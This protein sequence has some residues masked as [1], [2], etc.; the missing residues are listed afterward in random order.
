MARL[1]RPMANVMPGESEAAEAEQ[2][3]QADEA[4]RD[5]SWHEYLLS[6]L[7]RI[8][9]FRRTAVEP[10]DLYGESEPDRRDQGYWP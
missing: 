9:R 7:G 3:L 2:D 5:Q 10:D 8:F 4:L 1:N 6:V